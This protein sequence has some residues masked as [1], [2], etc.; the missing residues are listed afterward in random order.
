[1]FDTQKDIEEA[2]DLRIK[3]NWTR[4]V[5]LTDYELM[6]KRRVKIGYEFGDNDEYNHEIANR[7]LV[8]TYKA[9]KHTW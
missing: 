4:L 8:F 6:G 3:D 9:R 7:G 5:Y 2:I 1:M